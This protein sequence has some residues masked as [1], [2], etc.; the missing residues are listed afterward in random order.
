MTTV[1]IPKSLLAKF[2][3]DERRRE[4][5]ALILKDHRD[6]AASYA[7]FRVEVRQGFVVL[8]PQ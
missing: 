5:V 4:Y 3:W 8:S 2:H 6:G 7:R 1:T